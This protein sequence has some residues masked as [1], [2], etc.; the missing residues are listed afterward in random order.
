MP[1][2]DTSSQLSLPEAFFAE[3]GRFLLSWQAGP[4]L[5][6]IEGGSTLCVRAPDAQESTVGAQPSVRI[7]LDGDGVLFAEAREAFASVHLDDTAVVVVETDL[8][9]RSEQWQAVLP[10]AEHPPWTLQDVIEGKDEAG[11]HCLVLTVA[12]ADGAVAF[13]QIGDGKQVRAHRSDVQGQLVYWDL[14]HDAAVI[15]EDQG[16]WDPTLH[17]ERPGSGMGGMVAAPVTARWADGWDRQGAVIMMDADS[18]DQ[19]AIWDLSTSTLTRVAG[20]TGHIDDARIL[21][22]GSGRLLIVSTVEGSDILCLRSAD[23]S[24]NTP[25]P[26]D[27]TGRTRIR[28]AG[29]RGIGMYGFSTLGGSTWTWL[30]H[31]G[32]LHRARG[33]LPHHRGQATSAHIRYGRTPALCYLPEQPP[34]AAVISLHGGPES[35]ERDELRWDGLYRDLLDA[36]VAVIGLNYAGSTGYGTEHTRRAW[37]NWRPAFQ[38][39]LEA[40]VTAARKQGVPPESIA[41]LGGSFGGALALLGCVLRPDLAGAVA[42]APLVDIR[43]HAEYARATDPSYGSWFDTRFELSD[44]ATQAQRIFSPEYLST[45]APGQ[46]VVLIHG[47]EDEVTDWRHSKRAVDEAHRRGLPWTLITESGTGHVPADMT[48]TLARFLNVRSALREVLAVPGTGKS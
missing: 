10:L 11:E 31:S 7:E 20:V 29:P 46:R 18:E 44:A 45:T 21:R 36:G 48:G 1:L 22:D 16:P 34:V 33:D 24:K 13:H 17:L 37:K 40:G 47:D 39:D 32:T 30:D 42:S 6:S 35:V 25:L 3:R 8:S 9:G 4:V 43:L 19:L 26:P 23:G 12:D 2:R 28:T 15:K 5:G 41:L 14:R 38:E 27:S